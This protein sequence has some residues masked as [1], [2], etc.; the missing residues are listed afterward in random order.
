MPITIRGASSHQHN[1][2]TI[3][4]ERGASEDDGRCYGFSFVY[5]GN[6]MCKVEK[7]QYD[8]T[9]IVMGIHPKHFSYQLNL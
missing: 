6:F 2:F 7:D 1:P 5:S 3:L 4:C 9:R 8:Q